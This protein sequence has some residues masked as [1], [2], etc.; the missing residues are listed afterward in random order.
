MYRPCHFF[1]IGG[2]SLA[3]RPSLTDPKGPLWAPIPVRERKAALASRFGR[4]RQRSG[5]GGV[6]GKL[7]NK[8]HPAVDIPTYPSIS[9]VLMQGAG[10]G[11]VGQRRK[12]DQAVAQS[13]RP[14]AL[15]MQPQVS[16]RSKRGVKRDSTASRRG[17]PAIPRQSC[18][19]PATMSTFLQTAQ[20]RDT[21]SHQR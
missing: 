11:Y 4:R 12:T 14:T 15:P 18:A 1:V 8:I 21:F 16:Q 13:V 7:E 19:D 10:S 6:A 9:A 3:N 2:W 17:L 5:V 20:P